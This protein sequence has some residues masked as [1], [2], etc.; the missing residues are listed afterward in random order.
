[1]NKKGFTLV[2][3]LAV[4]IVMALLGGI[5]VFG[6]QV[7][8]RTSEERYYDVIESNILLAGSDYFE[9]HRSELPIGVEYREVSLNDLISKNYIDPVKDTKGNLCSEGAVYAYREGS[10]VK[11]DVCLTCGNYVS[12]FCDE[13]DSTSKE[14]NITGRVVGGGN[15][16]VLK[17]YN[18]QVATTGANV[19]TTFSMNEHYVVS[20]YTVSHTA[21][22]SNELECTVSSNNTC[23]VEIEAS[24]TYKVTAYDEF[25]KVISSRY[26]SVRVGADYTLNYNHNLFAARSQTTN[27][28]TAEYTEDGSYLTLN[29]TGTTT[30]FIPDL[31]NLERRTFTAGEKYV[32][33]VKYISG[34]LTLS[35]PDT[36]QAPRLVVDLSVNGAHF[37]DRMEEPRSSFEVRLPESGEN[38]LTFTVDA[39]RISANGLHYWLYQGESNNGTFNNYKVQILITKVDNKVVTNGSAYGTLSTP[40]KTGYDFDGWYTAPTGGV[41]VTSSDVYDVNGDQTLYAHFTSHKLN[42]QYNGNGENVTWC[43]TG[44][45]R[46][47][48]SDKYAIG[49]TS[50]SRNIQVKSFGQYI[51]FSAGLANFDNPDYICYSKTGYIATPGQE[52]VLNGH[53]N[54]KYDQYDETLLVNDVANDSGCNL[55]TQ[56]SCTVRMDVN[57]QGSPHTLNYN[58]NLFAATMQTTN[59]VT[60][61]YDET[62]SYM[63]LNGTGTAKSIIP[64]LWNYERRSIS[65]GDKYLITIKYISG[66]LTK[67]DSSAKLSLEF[68]LT[69]NGERFAD[70]TT[71]P[72][73]YT[74]AT[75]PTSGETSAILTVDPSRASANGLQYWIYEGIA[76]NTTF[77]DYRVQ[78]LITKVAS[79]TVN[80]GSTYG[81]LP[82]PTK[83]GYDFD[84]WYTSPSGGTEVTSSTTYN[85]DADQTIYAHF[86][87]HKLN[88]QYN[89]NGSDAWCGTGTNITMDSSKYAVKDSTR[90]IQTVGYGQYIGYSGGLYN[91]DNE[92]SIC[93]SRTGYSVPT[94]QEWVLNGNTSKKYNDNDATL[95]TIDVANDAGCNLLT[96]STCNARMNVNWKGNTYTVTYI[97]NLFAARTQNPN[98]VTATY[99]ESGSY[100]T[101]D[102]ITSS[103][104]I[105]DPLWNFDRRT[106]KAN[107]Q[108]KI[109]IKYVS[110][111]YTRK[112]NTSQNPR[113]Y[114]ELSTDGEEFS[115]RTTDP[116]SYKM[117]EMPLSGE[118]SA[119]FTVDSSRASANGLNYRIYQQTAS[120]FQFDSYKVQIIITKV[121]SKSVTYGSTYG[122]LD[123]SSKT[124]FTFDGWYTGLTNGSE[125]TSSTTYNTA[126]NQ[127]LYAHWTYHKLHVRYRSS[128][129]GTTW[130]GTGSYTM[131]SSKY[132]LNASGSRDITNPGYGQYINYKS[133]FSDYQ[134][135]NSI[136][137]KRSGHSARTGKEW[138]LVYNGTTTNYN[139]A[140]TTYTAASVASKAGCNLKNTESCT[141]TVNVY[142]DDDDSSGGTP[143]SS[144]GTACTDEMACDR[145]GLGSWCHYGTICYYNIQSGV[146]SGDCSHI[147]GTYVCGRCYRS[148]VDAA[149]T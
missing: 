64:N 145:M 89:G 126:G 12:G 113:F 109:T 75:L 93:F 104:W 120:N 43:G 112:V 30:S 111:S 23:S 7:F 123:S 31:W 20:K 103:K 114:F 8:F 140:T 119:T 59:G 125:K 78:V 121:H 134:N 76:G 94:G 22:V 11:Y 24:G 67:Q 61:T 71:D 51:D 4:I 62:N 44:T 141:A 28:V 35:N 144:G 124:G 110:G 18:S 6:Y 92:N 133:G 142:W 91:W 79:K 148:V 56:S 97:D 49:A 115:D 32:V 90:N 80:Y 81:T 25:D 42:I 86:T 66:T 68:D 41:K 17:P 82:T 129:S 60:V 48:D 85:L 39:S 36:A 84:G 95:T 96:T 21:V 130:C 74:S 54:K 5:G 55:S 137:F 102:G 3:L 135:A 77:T 83:T 122:T 52:W 16:D 57:W 146:T 53:T 14:I 69:T 139:Q 1:M 37:S 88:V 58:E 40:T 73:S 131:D 108:Y 38:I 33:T 143:T 107:D 15:Y 9:D 47:M 136:C 87:S 34:T 26:M 98:G 99:T 147:G 118:K 106:I 105:V 10:K 70:R 72:K 63:K 2:E 138:R 128:T 45:S 116:V 127:T 46:E 50:Q 117:V 100:L 101:L 65:A 132:A 29:G 19:I 149:C 13:V 27:G